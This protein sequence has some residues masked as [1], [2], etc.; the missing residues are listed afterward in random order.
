[1][2]ERRIEAAWIATTLEAPERVEVL[3]DSSGNV[4]YLKRIE[5]F[6]HRWLRVIVNPNAS[7]QSRS[8]LIEG[9]NETHRAQRRCAVFALG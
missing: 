3:A 4:H 6:E 7:P 1:M 2:R 9:S 8:F 5:A